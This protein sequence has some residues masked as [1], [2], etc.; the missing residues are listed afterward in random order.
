MFK[1]LSAASTFLA[2]KVT[3]AAGVSDSLAI[4]LTNGA[5]AIEIYST[6]AIL[7]ELA[8]ASMTIEDLMAHR[9]VLRDA[10][11]AH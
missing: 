4:S 3:V 7:A 5:L 1:Q 11:L 9:Q 2:A 8:E 6:K 10:V